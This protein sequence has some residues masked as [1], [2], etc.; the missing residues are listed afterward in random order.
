MGRHRKTITDLVEDPKFDPGDYLGS[1][2]DRAGYCRFCSRRHAP[3]GV[4]GVCRAKVRL[5]RGQIPTTVRVYAE[6][7]IPTEGDHG[8]SDM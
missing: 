8:M 6:P 1:E 2:Y 5:I 4:C 7:V 3:N